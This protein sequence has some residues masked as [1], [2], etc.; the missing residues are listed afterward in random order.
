VGISESTRRGWK[1]QE[2]KLRASLCTVEEEAGL[3]AKRLKTA[4]DVKLDNALYG[5]FVQANS[6]GL[7]ISSSI[8]KAQAKKFDK[9]TNRETSEFKAS[10][11]RLNRFKNVMGYLVC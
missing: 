5:W 7:P 2:Q 9:Q 11:G 6:E 10:N 8:L 1:S 3:K 4:K